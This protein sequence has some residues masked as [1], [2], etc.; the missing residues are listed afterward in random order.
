M[1]LNSEINKYIRATGFADSRFDTA[2]TAEAIAGELKGRE[3][4][5]VAATTSAASGFLGAATQQT[6]AFAVTDKRMIFG[7]LKGLFKKKWNFM[8]LPL[9][10]IIEVVV[11]PR[12]YNSVRTIDIVHEGGKINIGF[13][14]VSKETIDAFCREINKVLDELTTVE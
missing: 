3:E 14:G 7:G 12:V 9:E 11:Q 6:T 10:D 8:S 4:V 1:R 2:A 5:L 13:R